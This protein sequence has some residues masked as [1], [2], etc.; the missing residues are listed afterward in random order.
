M[1]KMEKPM[2][3]LI[4]MTL[5]LLLTHIA[6]AKPPLIVAHRGASHAA[7]ENTLAAFKLAWTEKADGIEGDFHLTSD[8][9]VVCI[10]DTSLKRTTG[11]DKAVKNTSWSE[12]SKLDV[13]SW[14]DPAFKG[15]R[16][17]RLD[18]VLHLLPPDKLFFLEIKAGVEIVRPIELILTTAKADP[19][20]VILISFDA[21]VIR[22]CRKQMPQYQA[23]WISSLKDINQPGKAHQFLAELESTG[24]QG[25]QFNVKAPVSAAWLRSVKAKN[26]LLTSWVV[27]DV[28]TARKMVAVGVDH[29]TTNR[30]LLIRSGL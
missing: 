25:L 16:I 19:K 14:K 26:Y 20:R 21:G 1:R 3:P 12:L 17:P 29:I 2:K 9:E 30:P 15:E 22:E 13:G 7:P 11:I 6:V 10:H 5:S 24:A 27:D 8:G 28:A 4:V 23:H 18:D